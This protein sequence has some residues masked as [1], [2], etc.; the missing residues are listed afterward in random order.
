MNLLA[1]IGIMEEDPG[2][3]SKC[4]PRGGLEDQELVS[5]RGWVTRERLDPKLYLMVVWFFGFGVFCFLGFFG[6]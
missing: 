1:S 6:E 5:V 2:R 4:Q 3:P